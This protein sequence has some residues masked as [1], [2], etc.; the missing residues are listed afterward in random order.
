MNRYWHKSLAD[1]V[2]RAELQVACTRTAQS[3]AELL[4]WIAEY[5]A[6]QLY[7]VD[8]YSSM[9]RYCVEALGMSEDAALKRIRVAR[10]ARRFPPR[11]PVS[12]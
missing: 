9:V 4:G 12:A 3:D 7:L 5:D 11:S 8:A 10:I 6:R 1:H 2:V